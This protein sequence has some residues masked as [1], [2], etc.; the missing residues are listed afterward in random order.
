MTAFR[1][2]PSPLSLLLAWWLSRSVSGPV[3]GVIKAAPIP[4]KMDQPNNNIAELML[5]AAMVVPTP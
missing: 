2:H 3:A 1:P 5:K 4:S